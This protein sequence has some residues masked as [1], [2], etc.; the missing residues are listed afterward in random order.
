M[1]ART[2]APARHDAHGRPRAGLRRTIALLPLVIALAAGAAG[3]AS[4][5]APR[6]VTALT[7]SEARRS[8]LAI[9]VVRHPELDP[10]LVEMRVD[11]AAARGRLLA[12]APD[13]ATLAVADRIDLASAILSLVRADG[14]QLRVPLPGLLAAAFAPDASWLAILDGS[15][16]LWSV[17]AETGAATRLAGGPFL[18]PVT[19][20]P[21]GTVMLSSVASVEAPFISHLVRFHPAD[22]S[23][24]RLSDDQL[25]YG[26]TLLADGSIAVVAHE[27]GGTVV[28]RLTSVGEQQLA[29]LGPGAI[30][31]AISPDGGRIAWERHG[32][33]V[34]LLEPTIGL[35][36]RIGPGG[37]PRF[38]PDGRTLLVQDGE[39]T[40]LLGLD[41]SRVARFS[42]PAHFA[43]CAGEC[44]S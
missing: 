5:E 1:F 6:G 30:N 9:A 8:G 42:G 34:Y 24:S 31:V 7:A 15:G 13:A 38:S 39:G 23:V 20:E 29:A 43:A 32:E 41:G 22:G 21:G 37:R 26:S 40:A 25:V 10:A 2:R 16:S 33:G 11:G 36:R 12:V 35:A 17:V 3:I 44:E 4:A 28:S 18:G 19:V 14:S 27:P